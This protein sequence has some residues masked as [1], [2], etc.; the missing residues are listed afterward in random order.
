MDAYKI[1]LDNGNEFHEEFNDIDNIFNKY[2]DKIISLKRIT[3]RDKRIN[4][5][6]KL[7]KE[8]KDL[9]VEN[10]Q[11]ETILKDVIDK[12]KHSNGNIDSL[13]LRGYIKGKMSNLNIE[14]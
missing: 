7:R 14:L 11:M 8:K 1:T 5:I 2:G 4:E 12:L 13:K 3:K 10:E 9:Y 6:M